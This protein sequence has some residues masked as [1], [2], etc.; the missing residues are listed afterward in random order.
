MAEWLKVFH[1]ISVI[2]WMAGLL[3]L[4]RLMVYHS[5]AEIGGDKS[6]T[7]KIME[8]RL[9]NG[10]M[11]PAMIASWIFGLWLAWYNNLWIEG[12]FAVKITLVILLSMHHGFCVVWVKEFA[13]DERKR[14]GRFFR[15]VNEVPTV[16]MILV[17]VLV[18][19]QPF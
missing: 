7:F 3:Y 4:P 9:L 16:I 6:E 2:S 15:I 12:W 5:Q 11:T 19:I 17:V 13:A 14:T 1:L 8:R 18:I 10:I